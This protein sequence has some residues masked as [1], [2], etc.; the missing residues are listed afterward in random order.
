[1][2]MRPRTL[3][4]LATALAVVVPA[5][6]GHAQATDAAARAVASWIVVDAPPGSEGRPSLNKV[7]SGWTVDAWEIGR[8]HV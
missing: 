5:A 7:F 8:A 2:P 4:L 1:M 3:L 6:H